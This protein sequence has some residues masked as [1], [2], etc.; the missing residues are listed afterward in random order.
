MDWQSM[1]VFSLIFALTNNAVSRGIATIEH[2]RR[3][4]ELDRMLDTI[5]NIDQRI[6][7]AVA[8]VRRVK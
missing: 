6:D 7:R 1:V 8:G 4:K 3:G 5:S 2:W